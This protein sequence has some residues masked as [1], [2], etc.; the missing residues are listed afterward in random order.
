MLL[1]SDVVRLGGDA[2]D[3]VE[4]TTDWMAKKKLDHG[5]PCQFS[6][7]LPTYLHGG[8]LLVSS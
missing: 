4:S 3:K 5:V 2:V 1:I 8:I 7:S 6:I